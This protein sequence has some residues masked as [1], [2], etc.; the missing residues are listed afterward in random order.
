MTV[1]AMSIDDLAR[2]LQE[3]SQEATGWRDISQ[4]LMKLWG[5]TPTEQQRWTRGAFDY[6]LRHSDE[7]S[8]EAFIPM[9]GFTDGASYPPAVA[10]LPTEAKEV[11]RALLEHIDHPLVVCR[12]AHLLVAARVEKAYLFA[13][14]AVDAYLEAVSILEE[15][16]EQLHSLQHA[17]SLSKDFNLNRT[18]E[19]TTALTDLGERI[20]RDGGGKPGVVIP[21]LEV[22]SEADE[23]RLAELLEQARAEYQDDP[24]LLEGVLAI[25]RS[26]ARS[27]EERKSL[28][29][30]RVQSW[31]NLA[32]RSDEIVRVLHLETAALLAAQLGI[33]DLRRL[34]QQRLQAV[35]PT[36]LGMGK[37]S[38]EVELPGEEVEKY[39]GQ[40]TMFEDWKEAVVFWATSF[41]PPTGDVEETRAQ[42]ERN[43]KEFV[44]Q[45]LLPKVMMGGDGLPRYRPTTE[46][47]IQDAKLSEHENLW[48]Q[49]GIRLEVGALDRILIHYGRP[50]TGDVYEWCDSFSWFDEEEARAFTKALDHYFDGH[51]TACA[52][53]LTALIERTVRKLVVASGTGVYQVQRARIPGKYPGLGFLLKELQ[54][55]GLDE[56]WYRF[57]WTFLASP[58]GMNFRNELFH[59]FFLGTSRAHCVLLLRAV[60]YLA[61]LS[62]RPVEPG[63]A[64]DAETEPHSLSPSAQQTEGP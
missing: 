23:P 54:K 41:P 6:M 12:L 9:F 59:G 50:A 48:L 47:E 28:D 27:E 32:E 24:H 5:D 14:R 26:R 18:S 44:L 7:E 49:G 58:A 11:W 30:D 8:R 2:D 20:L 37:I 16:L 57:L 39:L 40:F 21:A 31:I 29:R 36:K 4:G 3:A 10:D 56:S 53:I 38:A 61:H 46:E 1:D 43:A 15:E 45:A 22:A 52:H 17:A 51:F 63:E 33:P 62:L 19:V 34:A 60:L 25:L 64:A 35:D 55:L 13:A 42:V